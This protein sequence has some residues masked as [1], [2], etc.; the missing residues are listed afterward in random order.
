MLLRGRETKQTLSPRPPGEPFGGFGRGKPSR[1][2]LPDHL[3]SHLAVVGE[4]NQA[5]VLSQTTW[6]AIWRLWERETKQTFFPRPPGK[7][8]GGCGKGK[9]SRRS[10]PDRLE[11]HLA[12]AGEGDQADVLSQTTWRAIWRLWERK[13]KQ[14]FSPRPAGKRFGGCG[15]GKPSRR[16]LPGHQ[17]SHFAVV[18]KGSKAD[19][20]PQTTW[21]AIWRLW[22]SAAK[23]TFSPRPPGKPFGGC[24]RGKPSRHSI[25][26]HLES[27]LA[28]V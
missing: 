1:R 23:Q 18:G 8:F 14:T 5:D 22:E 9:P 13:A 12:A 3:E 24:G 2:S 10:L 20:L 28:A 27:H 26:D 4:G 25:P 19:V 11:S 17:E 15:G 21:K 6:R 16:F 7:P